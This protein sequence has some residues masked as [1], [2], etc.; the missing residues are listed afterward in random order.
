MTTFPKIK[1]YTPIVDELRPVTTPEQK[2]EWEARLRKQCGQNFNIT[3]DM[4]LLD[5]CCGGQADDC[6]VSY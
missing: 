3:K 6:G 1:I 4:H 2:A 5:T